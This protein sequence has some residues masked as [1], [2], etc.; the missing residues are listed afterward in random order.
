MVNGGQSGADELDDRDAQPKNPSQEWRQDATSHL[1]K[2]SADGRYEAG[3]R[4]V[5]VTLSKDRRGNLV[6]FERPSAAALAI[7][8]AH[9]AAVRATELQPLIRYSEA[10]SFA[11]SVT[12]VDQDSTPMLFDYFEQCMVAVIFSFQA[13]EAYCNYVIARKVIG[14]YAFERRSREVVNLTAIELERQ[15]STEQKL[16]DILPALLDMASP[17]GKVVW[18]NFKVLKEKRDGTVHI[19][20]VDQA[21]RLTRPEDLDRASLFMGFIDAD[22]MAWPQHAVQLIHYFARRD[23]VFSWMEYLLDLYGIPREAPK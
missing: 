4:V 3:S 17:K 13:L 22:V 23:V 11:G 15:A 1:A 5:A 2:D 16:A 9:R 18:Q 8:I 7:N 19:K 6:S 10:N 20:S 14:T 12:S 21:P